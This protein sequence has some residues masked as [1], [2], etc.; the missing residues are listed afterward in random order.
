VRGGIGA[1]RGDIAQLH[2]RVAELVTRL[3]RVAPEPT[4]GE[5]GLPPASGRHAYRSLFARTERSE[6]RTGDSAGSTTE[7]PV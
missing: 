1:I 3:D 2:E 6:S 4:G 5:Q 7:R